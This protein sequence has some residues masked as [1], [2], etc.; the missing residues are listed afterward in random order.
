M[1]SECKYTLIA[2]SVYWQSSLRVR[3]FNPANQPFEAVNQDFIAKSLPH[4]ARNH[5]RETLSRFVAIRGVFPRSESDYSS[6]ACWKLL[7]YIL[8]PRA[9][10][11][12]CLDGK[13]NLYQRPLKPPLRGLATSSSSPKPHPKVEPPPPSQCS[14]L[15]TFDLPLRL[16]GCSGVKLSHSRSTKRNRKGLASPESHESYLTLWSFV[17]A[18]VLFRSVAVSSDEI[19]NCSGSVRCTLQ[20]FIWDLFVTRWSEISRF[21]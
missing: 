19:I 18:K 4:P 21:H 20:C 14:L 5:E 6:M 3:S 1:W 12:A 9:D 7:L 8:V 17:V 16:E 13:L 15:A 11:A 2:L 10:P